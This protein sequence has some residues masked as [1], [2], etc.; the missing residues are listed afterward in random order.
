MLKLKKKTTKKLALK[1]AE[2]DRTKKRI[3]SFLFFMIVKYSGN[4]RV[5]FLNQY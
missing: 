5:I 4:M 3:K 2:H 1:L